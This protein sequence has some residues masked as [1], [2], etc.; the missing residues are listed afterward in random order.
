M[1]TSISNY[2]Y[3]Q[4]S[5]PKTQL[6]NKV[7]DS[8]NDSTTQTAPPNFSSVDITKSQKQTQN[9]NPRQKQQNTKNVKPNIP[10]PQQK[11]IVVVEN[12]Q[13]TINQSQPAQDNDLTTNSSVQPGPS[14]AATENQIMVRQKSFCFLQA[15]Q[16][17]QFRIRFGTKT[18]KHFLVHILDQGESKKCFHFWTGLVLEIS[19]KLASPTKH[20]VFVF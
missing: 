15:D 5:S 3:T 2:S 11:Q 20:F 8:T 9:Q 13:P 16:V 10:A 6:R 4:E 17:D 14:L 19:E 7:L 18:K 12:G 1:A